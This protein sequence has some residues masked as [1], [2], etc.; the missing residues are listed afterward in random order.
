MTG[1]ISS[2]G[3][4][5][6]LSLVE[7]VLG[8]PKKD[9]EEKVDFVDLMLQALED[10]YKQENSG[11]NINTEETQ[12]SNDNF[13]HP[14]NFEFNEFSQELEESGTNFAKDLLTKIN[15]KGSY[16]DLFKQATSS[17]SN[18]FEQII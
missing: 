5:S 3:Y 6:G 15:A 11:E 12:N 9:D 7:E 17:I 16:A 8:K 18:A 10:S 2:V 14:T 1:P 13:G 4:V